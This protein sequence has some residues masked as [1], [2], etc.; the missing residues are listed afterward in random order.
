MLEVEPNNDVA[1]ATNYEG[2]FPVAF[3]GIINQPGDI[4][5]FRFKAKKDQVLDIRVIAR[6]LRSP[7][8]SVLVLYNAQGGGMASND[9]SGGPDSYLRF[10]APADGEYL[11][12]VTDHLHQGG[13][14]YTYRI[15]ITPVRA[16]A[17]LSIPEVNVN[18]QERQN[19][20]VP[21]GN[22]MATLIRGTRADFGG[23]AGD[24][25][26]R[27]APGRQDLWPKTWPP[28]WMWCR[29]CSKRRPMRRSPG[30]SAI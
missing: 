12:S 28:I 15:E 20:A 16:G 25:V 1:T 22:R 7:L 2:E 21:R 26:R 3:N 23:E 27:S 13:P 30:N 6:Q 11:V 24:S 17:T 14:D 8:D 9:D 5:F 10:T 19:I 29:W 18:S 4:D